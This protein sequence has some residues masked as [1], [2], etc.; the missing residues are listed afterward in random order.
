MNDRKE[1]SYINLLRVIASL[2]IASFLHYNY[3]LLDYMGIENAYAGNIIGRFLF[4][5]SV[6]FVELFFIISGFLF[7]RIYRARIDGGL[8]LD[9]FLG[10]RWKRIYPE[11]ILSI[12]FMLL[13]NIVI[14]TQTGKLYCMDSLNGTDVAEELLFGGRALFNNVPNINNAVWFVGVLMFCYLIAFLL[15]KL[16]KSI[17]GGI[18]IYIIPILIG[19]KMI[20]S[21]MEG[22]VVCMGIARGLVAFF[23]GIFVGLLVEKLKNIKHRNLLIILL[24][25][26]VLFVLL[27]AYRKGYVGSL[28]LFFDFLVWPE[29]M[30]IC[31]SLPIINRIGSGKV[32]SFLGDLSFSVYLW[33]IPM[34][35]VV[36][37]L[38]NAGLGI[39]VNSLL[40]VVISIPL[41]VAFSWAMHKLTRCLFKK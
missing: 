5:D 15:E 40:I 32:V 4:M 39:N 9:S 34:W 41:C 29:V 18:S 7:Y 31:H 16:G 22:N 38:V 28:Y 30:L 37:I 24:I 6:V 26:E 14:Y 19:V 25:L 8:S 3:H 12:L 10:S 21:S 20:H 2:I 36:S 17:N 11:L 35:M 27:F 1:T 13:G 23:L 33:N